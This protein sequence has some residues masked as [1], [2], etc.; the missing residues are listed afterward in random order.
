[1]KKIK[2][3]ITKDYEE[4]SSMAADV[5][6][7][8]VRQNN[9][10]VIGLATGSSPLGMYQCLARAWDSGH[11]SLTEIHGYNLDEYQ[12]LAKS[13][14][15]SFYHYLK[16]NLV[17][18]T[19]FQEQNLHVLDGMCEN[20]D[21]V[22]AD[23]EKDIRDAG[24]LDLQLLGLGETGHIGFN[25]PDTSFPRYTHQVKLEEKTIYGK[26]P[27]LYLPRSGT[28]FRTD[29]GSRHHNE[30]P[31][32]TIDGKRFTKSGNT[33]SGLVWR[34]KTVRTCQYSTIPSGCHNHCR[35]RCKSYCAG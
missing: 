30:F 29:N 34:G 33:I 12:G 15:Q 23:Y 11:I 25:E 2:L 20:T 27:F 5:V 24:G 16:T 28:A 17:D 32:N 22:C 13:N 21:S 3:I 10:S 7:E 14:P 31:E 4:M 1:M 18:T 9:K 35:R 19:D 8:Q 26:C 6:M